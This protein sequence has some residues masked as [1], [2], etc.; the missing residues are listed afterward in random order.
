[1][2]EFIGQL[3]I[4]QFYMSSSVLSSGQRYNLYLKGVSLEWERGP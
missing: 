3:I 2:H 4:E 1:M